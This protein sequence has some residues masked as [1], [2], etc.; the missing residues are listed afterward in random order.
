MK[1]TLTLGLGLCATAVLF[2]GTAS[3]QT[4]R[5]ISFESFDL[6]PGNPIGNTGSG[7]GWLNPWY[8]GIN[9]QNSLV[10]APSLDAIGNVAFTNASLT[11]GG[12]FR[13]ISMAGFENITDPVFGVANGPFL[14]KDDTTLW[15]SFWSHRTAFGDDAYGGVSFFIF[16]D[17]NGVGEYLF[18]G[19]P[20]LFDDWGI[21]TTLSGA[22]VG[23]FTA[24]VGGVDI[25]TNLVYRID[26]ASGDER[27][28][29]WVNPPV[30]HPSSTADID[31]MVPNFRFNEIRFQSGTGGGA[32][33]GTVPGWFFDGIELECQD[34]DLPSDLIGTP[35]TLPVLF[36]GAQNL[37]LNPGPAFAGDFYFLLGSL[38]GTAPG[39][40]VDS[41]LLPLNFDQYFL[42]TLNANQPPL[43]NSF[44]MLD[45]SGQATATFSIPPGL[46][47]LANA[48]VNHAYA[49]IDLAPFPVI[50]H[51]SDPAP[52][53]FL[54]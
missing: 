36:G 26:F 32:F 25:P 24:G 29:M 5:T 50:V 31:V 18:F 37:A 8:A 51:V 52:C 48:T 15:L 38:S 27:V 40:P 7:T 33:G 23:A 4:Y 41:F 20:F 19:S 14:G 39:F 42:S 44:G 34:C 12:S 49:V 10:F 22:G 9:N 2:A 43:A 46:F 6:T 16:L 28:R 47:V 54:P 35:N 45:G 53:T 13:R 21:D 30:E 17:P 1:T 11:D 3:A